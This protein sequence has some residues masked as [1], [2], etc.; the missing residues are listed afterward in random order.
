M[1]FIGLKADE[2]GQERDLLPYEYY[3]SILGEELY[4]DPHPQNEH[5]VAAIYY[6]PSVVRTDA[7]ME[8][9]EN[10][11]TAMFP[12]RQFLFHEF[13]RESLKF[14]NVLRYPEAEALFQA[15]GYVSDIEVMS[16]DRGGSKEP[17]VTEYLTHNRDAC[18]VHAKSIEAL[19][20]SGVVHQVAAG[21]VNRQ[22]SELLGQ[23]G[24]DFTPLINHEGI[25]I[26]RR[27]NWKKEII[28]IA[29]SISS[30][31]MRD[32]TRGDPS[33]FYGYTGIERDDQICFEASNS[34]KI[35][36]GATPEALTLFE[37]QVLAAL[38]K[39]AAAVEF[40]TGRLL[41]AEETYVATKNMQALRAIPIRD[42]HGRARKKG[43]HNVNIEIFTP[44]CD[45]IKNSVISSYIDCLNEKKGKKFSGGTLIVSDDVSN[46]VTDEHILVAALNGSTYLPQID[47]ETEFG[48]E[49]RL[50]WL[51]PAARWIWTL[52]NKR[53]AVLE[54]TMAKTLVEIADASPDSDINNEL[55]CLKR[56]IGRCLAEPVWSVLEDACREISEE[57]GS[58]SI[59]VSYA[60][61][62][63]LE[64]PWA[65]TRT[66]DQIVI[67][68][69]LLDFPVTGAEEWNERAGIVDE[70]G[71]FTL[72][73]R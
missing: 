41:N 62:R 29:Y 27:A 21:D 70:A 24:G 16:F 13:A 5:R 59:S 63:D 14:G 44:N 25:L 56:L 53:H 40:E 18:L 7:V 37:T 39:T 1:P 34:C 3:L 19:L 2:Y 67:Q 71:G 8:L 51:F 65:A 43:G 22:I 42:E 54:R 35:F 49:D 12:G 20:R 9:L 11:Y 33:R 23:F 66:D 52:K 36:A 10:H 32:P 60:W 15:R 73:S 46:V 48:R 68:G 38:R 55:W 64:H 57:E 58:R 28:H 47:L 61:T 50:L 30:E 4:R 72:H 17:P 69:P 26:P 31:E 6:D 45:K